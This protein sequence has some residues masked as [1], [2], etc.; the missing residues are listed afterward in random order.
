MAWTFWWPAPNL[1]AHQELS[2]YNKW[3]SYHF[4]NSKEFRSSVARIGAKDQIQEQNTLLAPLSS[5]KLQ[6][7]E[8]LWPGAKDEDQNMYLLCIR[9][10]QGVWHV[11]SPFPFWVLVCNKL[12]QSKEVFSYSEGLKGQGEWKRNH[13]GDRLCGH[14]R[15]PLSVDWRLPWRQSLN[16][17]VAALSVCA[18]LS[19]AVWEKDC[20]FPPF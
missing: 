3:H 16:H 19:Q 4:W 7:F 6:T 2:H 12:R 18:A 10:S 17:P 8:A 9:V 11:H 20:I 15:L 14:L 13:R 1:G 5:R